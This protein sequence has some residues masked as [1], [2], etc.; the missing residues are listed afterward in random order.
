MK[1]YCIV[2]KE[3]ADNIN[4]KVVRSKNDRVIK[5]IYLWK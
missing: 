4:P 3:K 1:T 5:M 2:C